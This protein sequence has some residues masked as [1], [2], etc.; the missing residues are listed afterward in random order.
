MNEAA[1]QRD[2]VRYLRLVLAKEYRVCAIPN[3]ARR[4]ASGKAANAVAGLTPGIAD[5]MIFG[6]GKCW[7]V[8]V[9]SQFGRLSKEQEI[10]QA[11]C[12]ATGH[13]YCVCRSL[14]D[15]HVALAHWGIPT[16]E[17]KHLSQGVE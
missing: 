13:P 4:T 1:V 16:R 10:V 7:F 6:R 9:K 5:L 17:A 14:D 11:W 8:E 3:A 15:M 12:A 2:I